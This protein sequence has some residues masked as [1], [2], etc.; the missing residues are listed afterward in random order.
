MPSPVLVSSIES[1]GRIGAV[2]VGPGG[3]WF[4]SHGVRPAAPKGAGDL[5]TACFTAAL[6]ADLEPEAALGSALAALAAAVDAA[7]DAD[8]FP[9][10]ALPTLLPRPPG[11]R[12]ERL[13]G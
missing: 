3:A 9:L 6:G 4:A 13:D 10:A 12:L 8:E 7:Q 5:L 2:Y 1:E 11:I